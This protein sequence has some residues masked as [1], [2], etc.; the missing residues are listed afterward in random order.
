M[1]YQS[2][3]KRYEFYSITTLFILLIFPSFYLGL[4]LM[5]IIMTVLIVVA[6]IFN[7]A[8][9]LTM[10]KEIKIENNKIIV[11]K[12]TRSSYIFDMEN[13]EFKW[14][15]LSSFKQ[16]FIDCTGIFFWRQRNYIRLITSEGKF[17]ISN[18]EGCAEELINFLKKEGLINELK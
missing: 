8:T 2:K 7:L 12:F 18:R 10:V 3:F 6:L 1:Q 15:K 4:S 5:N 16:S 14:L 9:Y 13:V 11:K 17:N